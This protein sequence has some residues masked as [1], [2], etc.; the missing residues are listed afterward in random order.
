V[1]STRKLSSVVG[2]AVTGRPL[3]AETCKMYGGTDEAVSECDDERGGNGCSDVGTS[4]GLG[5]KD[6]EYSLVNTSPGSASTT[7]SWRSG[8]GRHVAELADIRERATADAL[9][10]AR[11]R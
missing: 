7:E 3:G 6:G 8:A 1:C 11:D 2:G 4:R 10:G 9:V 5:A